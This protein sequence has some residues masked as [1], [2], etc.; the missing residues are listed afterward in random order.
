MPKTRLVS[1]SA[2]KLKDWYTVNKLVISKKKDWMVIIKIILHNL[3]TLEVYF[4]VSLAPRKFFLK[5]VVEVIGISMH[6][7]Y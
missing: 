3:R 5:H 1:Y 2:Y 7:P 4:S 6:F